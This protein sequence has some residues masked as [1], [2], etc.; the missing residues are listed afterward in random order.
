[1]PSS[2]QPY[3]TEVTLR[4]KENVNC[5][6]VTVCIVS[7][8]RCWL[9]TSACIRHDFLVH[10]WMMG[11][12]QVSKTFYLDSRRN[13]IGPLVSRL[14]VFARIRRFQTWLLLQ[15][16]HS[17]YSLYSKTP[18]NFIISNAKSS[19]FKLEIFI[20]YCKSLCFDDTPHVLSTNAG[21]RIISYVY[22]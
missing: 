2:H 10:V 12:G 5:V 7:M 1:M 19:F 20:L 16:G 22:I 17:I 15:I 18:Q 6:C 8:C 4:L 11:L 21:W 9:C 3:L 14:R 13:K